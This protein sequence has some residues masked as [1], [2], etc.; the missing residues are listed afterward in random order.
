MNRSELLDGWEGAEAEYLEEVCDRL[1][2][3]IGSWL[4]PTECLVL[5]QLLDDSVIYCDDGFVINDSSEDRT[6]LGFPAV[7]S[8]AAGFCRNS[9]RGYQ[10][11]RD[12][13]QSAHREI[14]SYFSIRA[15]LLE[16]MRN[17]PS[18]RS[19]KTF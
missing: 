3:V 1:E 6:T 12:R 11:F 4:S 13:V 10:W 8:I 18:V 19:V 5:A 9:S 16:R 15:N 14:S 7:S 17:H 2:P